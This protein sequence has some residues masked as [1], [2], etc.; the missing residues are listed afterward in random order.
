VAL[1]YNQPDAER[2]VRAVMESGAADDVSTV[3]RGALGK[4]TA[5]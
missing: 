1:G 4:L 2:A 5:K 3:V